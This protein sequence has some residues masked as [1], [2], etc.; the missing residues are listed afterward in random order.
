[1]KPA[2]EP[3]RLALPD[4]LDKILMGLMKG[5]RN[6]TDNH[7]RYDQTKAAIQQKL[8]LEYERGYQDGKNS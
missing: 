7:F 3:D 1:M 8:E 2:T 5:R 6:T 4:E